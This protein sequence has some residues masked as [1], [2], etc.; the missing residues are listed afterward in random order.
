MSDLCPCGCG[1]PRRYPVGLTLEEARAVKS[2]LSRAPIRWTA[3]AKS[4]LA[5]IDHALKARES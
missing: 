3:A 1:E 4:T 5:K 2:A